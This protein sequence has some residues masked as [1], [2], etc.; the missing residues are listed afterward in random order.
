MLAR[1]FVG[2]SLV[3]FDLG[4]FL[5]VVFSLKSVPIFNESAQRESSI[6]LTGGI[7]SEPVGHGVV[8]MKVKNIN[9]RVNHCKCKSWLSHWQ[10]YGDE[11]VTY[12][13]EESC[14]EAATAGALVQ[15]RSFIDGGW[16]IIPVCD[17][18]NRVRDVMKIRDSTSLVSANV[19]K[20]CAETRYD[21]RGVPH[22]N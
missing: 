16:Y 19:S 6:E 13:S 22:W 12:C 1:E 2:K 9:G 10:K 8:E 21:I 3:L 4:H 17:K 11:A 7:E 20:T 14:L 5:L 18:H 15:K